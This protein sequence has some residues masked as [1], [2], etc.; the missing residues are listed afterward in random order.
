MGY[1]IVQVR[2]LAGHPM[3]LQVLAEPDSSAAMTLEDCTAVSRQI[4]AVLDAA[5][6]I[7]S[8]YLLEVSSPGLDR[9]L[10]KAADFARFAGRDVKIR[11]RDRIDGRRSFRG[12]LVGIDGQTVRFRIDDE[13]VDRVMAVPLDNIAAARLVLP[14]NARAGQGVRRFGRQSP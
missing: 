8:G 5:D 12:Q 6:P 3:T 1:D 14:E 10:V 13:G 4:S 7:R 2:L 9:P 11:T